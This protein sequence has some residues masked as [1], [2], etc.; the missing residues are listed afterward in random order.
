MEGERGRYSWGV[1]R[2]SVDPR[3]YSF[4]AFQF[5]P[6]FNVGPVRQIGVVAVGGLGGGSRQGE[7]R[8]GPFTEAVRRSGAEGLLVVGLAMARPRREGEEPQGRPI[9]GRGW[10]E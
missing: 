2:R 1:S 4:R 3:G 8:L 7:Q 6:S 5:D 9:S 10:P